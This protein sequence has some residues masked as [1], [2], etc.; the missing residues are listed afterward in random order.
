MDKWRDF[1]IENL[2]SKFS[3]YLTWFK[4]MVKQELRCM[5]VFC[6]PNL[7]FTQNNNPNSSSIP[8]CV[9]HNQKTVFQ[10]CCTPLER[11]KLNPHPKSLLTL[12]E[13]E[14]LWFLHNIWFISIHPRVAT[15]MTIL[16]VTSQPFLET[17]EIDQLLVGAL[18]SSYS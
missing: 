7:A 6:G 17:L 16:R 13:I 5:V 9:M 11:C 14:R 3:T 1:Q 18:P 8:T 15:P 4:S 2:V 12:T 10:R